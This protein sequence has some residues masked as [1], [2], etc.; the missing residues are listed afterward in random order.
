MKCRAEELCPTTLATANCCTQQR[1]VEGKDRKRGRRKRR[2]ARW[3]VNTVKE[4]SHEQVEG[5]RR[6]WGA[7]ENERQGSVRKWLGNYHTT[8]GNTQTRNQQMKEHIAHTPVLLLGVVHVS[9]G[10]WYSA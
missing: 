10:V 6:R 8:V 4:L 2:R 5:R 1:R 3:V 7:H 9:M